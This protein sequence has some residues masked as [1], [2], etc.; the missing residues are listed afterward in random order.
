MPCQAPTAA[1]GC[2]PRQ[3]TNLRDVIS[4]VL[5]LMFGGFLI[6]IGWCGSAL[7][8]IVTTMTRW[9]TRDKWLATLV[10]PFGY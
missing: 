3:A 8:W 7:G 9:R 10:W 4:T 6:G 5:L 2:R 1:P